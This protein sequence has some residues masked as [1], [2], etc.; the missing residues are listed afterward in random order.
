MTIFD[1]HCHVYPDAIASRAAD[2]IGKFYNL[3]MHMS[4][5]LSELI[6]RGTAAGI[7]RFVINSAAV[8]ASRVHSI[9][10]Y[11]MQAAASD[12]EKLVGFGTMHPDYEDVCGELERI[13]KNGLRGVK[14]HPDFQHFCLDDE[15]AIAMFEAMARLG[16]PALIHTGDYRYPYSEPARMAR[17]LDRVPH[18]KVICAHLGGWSVWTDAWKELAGRPGV[19]VD[20]SSSLYAISPE[21]GA[22]VIRHYGADRVFFGTDYPMWNPKEEVQKF[23]RL[24]LTEEEQEKILHLNFEAFLSGL[25]D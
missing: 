6:T 18:L 5:T 3:N 2:S 19:W 10:D 24:P 20:T 4:G 13:K 12:P 16:L 8:T 14:L 15:M 23:L 1:V 7:S 11:L 9:N 17:V 25:E 22:E 21:E